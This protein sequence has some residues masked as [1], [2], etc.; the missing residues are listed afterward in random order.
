[1]RSGRLRQRVT[2]ETPTESQS[3]TTGAVSKTWATF[4]T[5]WAEKLDLSGREFFAARQVNAETTTRWRLRFVSGITK[6]MRITHG[7]LVY[8]ILSVLQPD[9]RKIVSEVLT[10]E[11]V[12]DA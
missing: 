7:G 11:G 9:G 5:R 1:M 3:A 12:I 6:K 10:S 8:A 2:I 4:A